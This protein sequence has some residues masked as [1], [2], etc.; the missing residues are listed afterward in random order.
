MIINTIKN[1]HM[2]KLR[3]IAC[4]LLVFSM[5]WSCKKDKHYDITGSPDV[6]FFVNLESPGN[7]P[8]NSMNFAI[9]NIPAATGGLETLSG[10]I[11]DAI[12]FPVLATKP[13]GEDVTISAELDNSLVAAYNDEHSTTYATIP[14]GVLNTAGLTATMP[15]GSTRTADSV[16]IMV[17]SDNL[18]MLTEDSYM[19]PVKLTSLSKPEAGKITSNTVQKVAYIVIDVEHRIIKY[20]AVAADAIGSLISPRTGWDVSYNPTPTL[21]NGSIIDGSTST[22]ARWN[23]SNVEVNVNMQGMKDVTGIRLYT[24]TTASQIPTAVSVYLSEDGINYKHIGSPLRANLTY[25]S[26]YNY[27][28]FYKEV[29]AQYLRLQI[30]YGTS[31][32]SQN[33]RL[34]ELDVYSN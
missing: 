17:N 33:R 9:T 11:G 13:V 12:K 6:T 16:T 2:S 31:S 4:S 29:P 24:T 21:S 15:A 18:K 3:L 1:P 7:A 19:V 23:V 34:A 32:T 20:N 28:L 27:I 22:F 30:T 10:N 26:S 5:L 8:V 25:A 14:D